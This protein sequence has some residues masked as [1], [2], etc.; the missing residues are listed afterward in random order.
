MRFRETN[1]GES[2]RLYPV[3]DGTIRICGNF[4][5]FAEML[6]SPLS[7]CLWPPNVAEW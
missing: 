2:K 5:V 4:T 1:N 7:Q 3:M 6:I